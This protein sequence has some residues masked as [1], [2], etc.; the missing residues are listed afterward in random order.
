[1]TQSTLIISLALLSGCLAVGPVEKRLIVTGGIDQTLISKGCE[2][3][4]IRGETSHVRSYDKRNISAETYKFNFLVP[5]EG[6]K[7][8]L[9][10][11]CGNGF[12]S[13][14]DLDI[15]RFKAKVTVSMGYTVEMRI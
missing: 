9:E 2:I 1:M 5:P 11:F 12:I 3:H 8:R 15:S 7:H 10:L 6:G 14:K 13:S 4:L